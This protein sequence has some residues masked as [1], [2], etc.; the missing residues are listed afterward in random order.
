MAGSP[1]T[2]SMR[3]RSPRMAPPLSGLLGSIA[4][5]ASKFSAPSGASRFRRSSRRRASEAISVLFPTP[6]G[7]VTAIVQPPSFAMPPSSAS[8]SGMEARETR[9]R[10]RARSRRVRASL[11]MSADLARRG[12][13]QPVQEI[14]VF[15]QTRRS[16]K[17]G[18]KPLDAEWQSQKA[19]RGGFQRNVHHQFTVAGKIA[20]QRLFQ[21]GDG[22]YH[23]PER[24]EQSHPMRRRFGAEQRLEGLH[25]R[26]AVRSTRLR[27][28]KDRIVNPFLAA[29]AA[30]EAGPE[31]VM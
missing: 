18:R 8:N 15:A 26:L 13:R 10:S 1:A 9:V 31:L 23:D 3:M 11:A 7:P 16:G 14:V 4:S 2:A 30:R 12:G 22:C 29:H 19:H 5:T 17:G 28:G 20:A 25:D 24:L 21:R 27:S 6:A